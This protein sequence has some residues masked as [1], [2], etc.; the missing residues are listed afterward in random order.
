[1]RSGKFTYP[2]TQRLAR[3]A[4]SF[5]PRGTRAGVIL[6][7]AAAAAL[8]LAAC[9]GNSTSSGGA[10]GSGTGTINIGVIGP[11]TGP[12]AEIGNLMSGACYAAALDVNKAGGVMGRKVS[13]AQ[14]DDTGDPADAVPNVTRALATT[15]NLNM[16]VGLES[17]TTAT[18]IP[19]VN[20]AHIPMVSTNGLVAYDKTTDTYFWRMTPSDD[21]NGAAFVAAGQGSKIETAHDVLDRSLGSEPS[22]GDQHDPVRE[23]HDLFHHVAHI[24]NGNLEL[25]AQPLD[26]G[27][28]LRLALGIEGGE[29]LVHQEQARGREK[30]AADRDPLLLPARE[31]VRVYALLLGQVH[32]GE[33]RLGLG[34][35]QVVV[36]RHQYRTIDDQEIGVGGG[37]TFSLFVVL[38]CRQRQRHQPVGSAAGVAKRPQV[39]L[40]RLQ[41]R[42]M[43]VAGIVASH[44]SD[45]M[46]V[47]K[48]G[49]GVYMTVG[50]I[51]LQIAVVEP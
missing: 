47:A 21:Q 12:A 37:Q 1:M 2:H 20:N 51:P 45:G 24:E 35:Q 13:C 22:V 39:G 44:V 31:H 26:E 18:T 5:R 7:G 43:G 9:G 42:V 49:E 36:D 48:T 15:S 27:E 17:N 10:S 4:A 19:L 34:I 46:G 11:M 6:T 14:I 33:Q 28:D 38:R 41:L 40:H 23:P 8:V 16:A 50:V 30:R 32:L 29:R 3:Q 25:V